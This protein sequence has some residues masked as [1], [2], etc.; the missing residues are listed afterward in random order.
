MADEINTT[1]QTSFGPALINGLGGEAGFG[2]NVLDR[3][4][5]QSSA[6][7]DITPIFEDG[8]NFFGRQFSSL[9]V[10]NNGSV[11][12]NGA[13]STYTPNV[14]TENN[15]NPEI[16]PF[17]ADVDT[18]G[19]AVEA[20]PGG[21]STGSN[22]VYYDFDAVNDRF[23]VTW[24]DVGYYSYHTELTNAFQLIISDEGGGNF[25]FEFRY[26]SIDWTT[27]GASG[28]VGGLGGTVARAGWTASTGDPAAYFEL[29]AS[30]DQEGILNLEQGV[31]NTGL[32]G[33]WEFSVRSGDIISADLPPLP[34]DVISGWTS[35]DPHL[36]TLDGAAYDYH[37]AGEYVLLRATNGSDFEVQSRMTPIANSVSVNSAIATRMGGVNVMVDST[38][39]IPLSIDGVATEVAD[40][41]FVDV[42]NDRVYREGNTYTMLFAGADDT[43][44]AG[45]SRI[46]VT[47]GNGRVDLD[48][49]LN[50]DLAGQLEGL[51]G[52]AD[53]I[54][55]NDIALADGT[56]LARPL[57]FDDLYGQYR[58][59]WRVSTTADSL[60]TY[61][62][63][64]SLAGFY[65]V[66]YPGSTASID[67]FSQAEVDAA[68]AAVTAAGLAP[69][70]VNFNNAVLDFA[71]TQ[72]ASYIASA[73]DAQ[74]VSE[75][76]A[77]DVVVETRVRVIGTAESDTLV[78]ARGAY[79]LLGGDGND[80][81]FGDGK[82]ASYYGSN[83]ANQVFRLY[84][85]TLDREPD[86]V[87]H[88]NWTGRVA[89]GEQSLQEVANG[90][91]G[92][93]EFMAAFPADS[94]PEAF[95][96]L[97]YQ[98]VLNE[99]NPDAAGLARWVGELTAE[100]DARLSRA[101]VVIGFSESPQFTAE[102]RQEANTYARESLT[103]NWSDDVF[104]LYQATLDRAP[105]VT[106]QTNWTERLATGEH[107]LL[108]VA[109]GFVGS[110]EFTAAFP[111]DATATAFVEL[112][113]S[114]VLNTDTPDAAGL[115]RW[116]DELTN[117]ASRA[118]V[119]L[120]FSQSPQFVANTAPT[121]KTWM[122]DQGVDDRLD[123]G[124]GD[125]L[126]AGGHFADT[127]IFDANHDSNNR[128]ADLEA[129]DF[130]DLNGFGY[131]TLAQVRAEMTES[132]GN[133]VFEDQG[134]QITFE[135]TTLAQITDDMILI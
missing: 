134:V 89:T 105:D 59:D 135:H 61:D 9:W 69:G 53:G 117:G 82:S 67:T 116:V 18:R 27:G 87:G 75:T 66:N 31:G 125:N 33:R 130:I 91:V 133:V 121:L 108:E 50:T 99:A 32:V 79:T 23:I 16:T 47:V 114:N 14:I 15:A 120:G 94:T 56:P 43:V 112:L 5:D 52:N 84:Q 72:D 115:A 6:E 8:L 128:V 107:T 85:A 81:L 10:N 100:G 38:D 22:N 78:G 96:R 35:G 103:T 88:A 17:F 44:N 25:D 104:R 49:Q 132:N 109:E 92:S 98:N 42:G 30:G 64:E 74:I 55:D 12:F 122:R 101:E 46:A 28:G 97:L 76:A 106:G 77:P 119:V 90:F 123:G 48:V 26:E 80:Y 34:G 21:N 70:T 19:G 13:R 110:P 102:T 124:S 39:D 62:A 127:F 4:D 45:D 73:E 2:E 83:T 57:T 113:Y 95:V 37:A 51:L 93:P 11:T 20:S 131:N 71:L 1:D 63:G 7:I 29:P 41:G 126:M 36:L 54:A 129:W 58:D 68:I 24:D 65:D 118:E 111:V 60:F 86:S 40:F 3:N